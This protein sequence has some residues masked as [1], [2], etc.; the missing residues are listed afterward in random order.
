MA[1]S[2]AERQKEYRE[3]HARSDRINLILRPGVSEA[4]RRLAANW[5]TT[6]T[7]ALERLILDRDDSEISCLKEVEE[8]KRYMEAR[9]NPNP[10]PERESMH[11]RM[12][13][14]LDNG[15]DLSVISD[16]I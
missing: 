3:R 9:P 8:L 2:G 7:R 12:Q 16:L 15:V 4:L 6:Q 11:D 10:E 5:G 1:K 13:R 14:Y